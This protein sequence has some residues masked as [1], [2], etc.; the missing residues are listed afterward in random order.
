MYVM[1]PFTSLWVLET[2][3][4]YERFKVDRG[5][6]PLGDVSGPP[7]RIPQ[8]LTNP[9]GPAPLKPRLSRSRRR[10]KCCGRWSARLHDL[11]AR[12]P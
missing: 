4:D 3:A 12:A 11:A 7:R 1:S 5:A 6:G 10:T 2:D 9:D 8:G